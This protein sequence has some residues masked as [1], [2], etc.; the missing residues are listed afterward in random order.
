MGTIILA[1]H[2]NDTKWA[3]QDG[4]DHKSTLALCKKR[5]IDTI[6]VIAV[7]LK[8]TNHRISACAFVLSEI[9]TKQ[10]EEKIT[11]AC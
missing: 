7:I 2:F 6:E 3:R 9:R 11:T 4:V 1:S 10:R 8:S 5:Y